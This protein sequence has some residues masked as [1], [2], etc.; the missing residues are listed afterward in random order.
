M[1][2]S[3]YLNEH[4]FNWESLNVLASGVSPIDSNQFLGGFK[5]ENDIANFLKGYGFDLGDPIQS[6]EIFGTFQESIQFIRRYFLKEGNED[7]LDLTIPPKF[8]TLTSVSE[9]F[10]MVSIDPQKKNLE[11]SIWAGIILKVMHVI[12]H[13]DKD[14][15][16]RY[17]S[18]TQMQ[19]FD[20]FYRYLKR[21]EN[22]NLF[23]ES[24]KGDKVPLADFQTKSKK[25]R[26]STI[27]K[28]LHKKESVAEEL[29]D[30]IGVRFVTK[31]KFDVLRVMKFLCD[32][33]VVMIHNVKPSRSFNT[34]FDMETVRKELFKL[35]KKAKQES[36]KVEDYYNEAVAI[37]SKD[38]LR[39]SK[40]NNKHTLSDYRAI[41]F[42]CRQLIKYKNPFWENFSKVRA[43]AKEDNS[44]LATK[45][46]ELDTSP[47]ARDV[48]FFY[49][50]EVQV[51]DQ[52]SYK[53]NSEG[54]AA[55][56]EY[57]KSQLK[58]AMKRVFHTL[59][60][61]KKIDLEYFNVGSEEKN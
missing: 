9:L 34:M 28:L 33:Y 17:F 7:G 3:Q 24:D 20:R 29:F 26:E 60:W 16:A 50:F 18:T 48:R 44:L 42:T 12:I 32:N 6:A 38:E 31:N 2:K 25:T 37:L 57:K 21:D 5:D 45:I 19:I 51:T 15:R 39:I 59:I 61:Y 46:L 40:K 11:E 8:Y 35:N 10:N 30:R 53:S 14:L 13:V 52:E 56:G 4:R 47:I 36:Y 41:H 27:I 1:G 49:P 54:E 22:D 43:V 55:H 58:S 23:L